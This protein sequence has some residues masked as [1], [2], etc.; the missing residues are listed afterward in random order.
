MT[1]EEMM[2]FYERQI[3]YYTNDIAWCNGEL[4]RI[5]K[6]LK[7]QR[8]EYN[9]EVERLWNTGVLTKIDMWWVTYGAENTDDYKKEVKWRTY[10]YKTRKRGI[11]NLADY[12]RRL[13]KMKNNPNDKYGF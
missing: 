13:E 11:A 1:R 2:A 3:E 12:T 6:E 5:K 9:A 4:V 8:D 7:K 10:I